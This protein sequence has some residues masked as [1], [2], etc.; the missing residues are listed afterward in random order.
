[1]AIHVFDW[2]IYGRDYGSKEIRGIWDEPAIVQ[3]WLDVEVA[4]AEVQAEMGM[5]PKKAAKEIKAK[6]SL[7][8]I[9]LERIAEIYSK[10]MLASVAMTRAFKEV[11]EGDAGEYIHYGA[12][13]QDIFDSSLALRMK[14]SLD[15]FEAD[16]VAI[17]KE[18]NKLAKKYKRAYMPGHTHG[19]QAIPITFGYNAAIWS[20][21]VA[22]HIERLRQ[23][24]PRIIVGSMC[25]AA[26]NLASF[27]L[28]FG[29]NVWE[30]Q[31]RVL[32]KLGLNTPKINI[33]PCNERINEYLY[34]LAQ[35]ST[36][37]EK[38]ADDIFFQ[39]RNELSQ[40][41]EPFDT[42]HQICSSTM[43]QKRNPVRCE[44]IKAL[45][46]KLRSNASGFAELFMRDLRDYSAFILEDLC[47]PESSILADTML[48]M[49]KYVF[50]GL[51]V[52]TDNMRKQLDA[53]EG[54]IMSE[55][56]ALLLS[57][58]TGKKDTAMRL[59][60]KAAME[61]FEKGIPYY[62]YVLQLPEIAKYMTKQELEA[63]FNPE[64][65]IGLNDFLIEQVTKK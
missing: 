3:D 64:N 2:K 12:T 13:T 37:F 23:A 39:Q 63:A 59:M 24:R 51:D 30:M 5:I 34:L 48:K 1:M 25:A 21:M 61:A 28:L 60:H 7:K 52:R 11:C 31:K 27:K 20:E 62:E 50:A 53:T 40:L 17:R 19:Q 14:R 44:I 10:T 47:M 55:P 43:P 46:K 45:A 8:H 42:E 54:L 33:Q 18:L 57:E 29:D 32:D 56:L 41:E 15:I 9:K 38:I 65:Y 36:T 16:L 6:G 26:G 4:L 58:K 49:A 35:I 22:G